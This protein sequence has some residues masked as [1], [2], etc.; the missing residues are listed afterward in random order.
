LGGGNE[1]RGLDADPR[2]MDH[3]ADAAGA[4][5][6]RLD[7]QRQRHHKY[8]RAGSPQHQQGFREVGHKSAEPADPGRPRVVGIDEERIET[9]RCHGG[10]QPCEPGVERGIGQFDH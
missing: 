10:A 1:A 3:L 4:L 9:G 5:D 6:P 2:R 7:P 8:R